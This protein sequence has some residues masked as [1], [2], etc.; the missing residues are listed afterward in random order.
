VYGPILVVEDETDIR[1]SIV[2]L[3]R[4]D[5]FDAVSATHGRD[6]LELLAAGLEPCAIVLDMLMPVM[7]GEEFFAQ[8]SPSLRKRVIVMSASGR[9][10]VGAFAWVPKPFS[11]EDLLIPLRILCGIEPE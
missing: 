11:S 9:A 7:G 3:L 6:A 8:L 10:P 5:G 2:E 1:E 4:A